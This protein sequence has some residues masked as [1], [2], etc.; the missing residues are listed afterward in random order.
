MADGGDCF[1]GDVLDTRVM[2][3]ITRVCLRRDRDLSG[4]END[5][6]RRD[7]FFVAVWYVC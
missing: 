6:N 4:V 7:N 5:G 2:L 1:V 3:D